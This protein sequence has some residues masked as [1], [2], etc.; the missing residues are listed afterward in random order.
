MG[1]GAAKNIALGAGATP[2]GEAYDAKN[3]DLYVATNQG[4][5]EAISTSTNTIVGG[6]IAVDS[7][8]G[9]IA[10][11]SSSGQV[12]VASKT[13]SEVYSFNPVNPTGIALPTNSIPTYM[14]YNSFDGKIYVADT[15]ASDVSII[16]PSTDAIT[17][18]PLGSGAQPWGLAYDVYNG[19]V[20]AADRANGD[21]KVISGPTA[22]VVATLTPTIASSGPTGVAFDPFNNMLYV[23]G[24]YTNNLF[25]FNVTGN[26][27]AKYTQYTALNF[28][29]SVNSPFGVSVDCSDGNVWVAF[30]GSSNLLVVN[31]CSN[32]IIT[33]SIT[34]GISSPEWLAF[35]PVHH[36]MYVTNQGSGSIEA[37]SA[38]SLALTNNPDC[39]MGIT[40]YGLNGAT[41]APYDTTQFV[42]TTTVTSLSIGTSSNPAFNGIASVQLNA[43]TNGIAEGAS[44]SGT[45]WMQNVVDFKTLGGGMYGFDVIDNI[46]NFQSNAA[47][48]PADLHYNQLGKC[49]VASNTNFY[50][51]SID[52]VTKGTYV[53]KLTL[54]FTIVLNMTVFTAKSG[55]YKGN[56]TIAFT[57]TISQNGVVKSSMEYDLVSFNSKLAGSPVF[58][59]GGH[60]PN[61]IPSDAENVFTGLASLAEV[62]IT[63]ISATMSLDY[64]SGTTLKPVPHAS[65]NSGETGESVQG[66][67]ME[68]VA[69]NTAKAVSGTDDSV[70]LW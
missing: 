57:Y 65:G 24:S 30:S 58:H 31:T 48:T 55:P 46:W 36:R 28:P 37:I 5:F 60:A 14:I 52:D 68:P 43:V 29:T 12:F 66:V 6:K 45:Y 17:N 25:V 50:Y 13:Q 18:V 54:P 67:H 27:P 63:K 56:S 4:Y 10:V 7:N 2:N 40:D 32:K 59:V 70:Q 61:K 69:G 16:N 33:N 20:F 47:T 8:L 19:F 62:S 9:A 26:T 39:A 35:D 51:C 3:K 11:D 42:S 1:K 38:D 15:F 64:L 21:I 49:M 44:T 34:T 41:A 23:T 22:S 53:T